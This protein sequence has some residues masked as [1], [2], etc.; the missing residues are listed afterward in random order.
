MPRNRIYFISDAHLG[1]RLSGRSN[2]DQEESLV[3]FLRSIR[4]DAEV[5]YIVGDLFDFWFEY[6]T[7]V[8]ARAGK[9]IF[10]LHALVQD[11]VRVVYLPG[12]HDIW[13]GDYLSGQVGLHLPGGPIAV[14]HHGRR[15]YVTHGDELRESWKAR[16]KRWILKNPVCI[17]L[18][19]LLHPDLGAFLASTTSRLS[20]Y[21]SRSIANPTRKSP[22]RSFAKRS[23]ANSISSSAD[24]FTV[25]FKPGWTAASLSC[26]ETGSTM[27]IMQL[28]KTERYLSRNGALLKDMIEII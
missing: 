22:S 17:V 28:W 26:W 15:I 7:V 10:A 8:P 23:H 24:T 2:R 14:E 4:K 16:L 20:N 9:V 19:R 3:A 21:R 27:T 18:F 11:G 12:N 5:L 6:R 1:T 25:R 13:L